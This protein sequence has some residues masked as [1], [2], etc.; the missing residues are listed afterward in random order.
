MN[1]I[2]ITKKKWNKKHFLK[3]SK[4]IIIL[5][6]IDIKKI[7]K[8][9]PKVIFTANGVYGS[10]YQARYIAECISKGTK[11]ILAQHGGRYE[12]LKRFFPFDHEVDIC[13]YYIT[14]GQKN[15]NIKIKNLGIIKPIKFLKTKMSLKL[16]PLKIPSGQI[17][18]VFI[19]LSGLLYLINFL[20]LSPI[21]SSVRPYLSSKL[22]ETILI[23]ILLSIEV[24]NLLF[25]LIT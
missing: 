14:W 15:N 19:S 9:N 21:S 16:Y 25:E 3:L 20:N 1:Y 10:S 18:T 12:N 23:N 17:N 24:K 13:N 5:K 4:K 22:G 2:I 6:K 7:I 11:L 8:I